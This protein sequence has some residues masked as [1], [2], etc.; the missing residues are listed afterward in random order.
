M[1]YVK[2]LI[3]ETN[4]KHGISVTKIFYAPFVYGKVQF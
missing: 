1:Q 4:H 3:K 2:I